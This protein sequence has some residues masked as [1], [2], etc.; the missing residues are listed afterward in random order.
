[1]PTLPWLPIEASARSFRATQLVGHTPCPR[2]AASTQRPRERRLHIGAMVMLTG[3]LG[4]HA[5]DALID[6]DIV[7]TASRLLSQVIER[8]A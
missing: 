2:A 8:D 5:G 3:G 4:V 6:P 1:M 7:W